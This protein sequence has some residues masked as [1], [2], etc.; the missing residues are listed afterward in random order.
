M[1]GAEDMKA[2]NRLLVEALELA[3]N[4]MKTDYYGEEEIAKIDTA[5]KG[6]QQ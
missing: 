4:A 2:K 5:L 1:M 6:G 3:R